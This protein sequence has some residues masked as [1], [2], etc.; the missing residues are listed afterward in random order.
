MGPRLRKVLSDVLLVFNGAR[1]VAIVLLTVAGISILAS[2]LD[3]NVSTSEG[4]FVVSGT[5]TNDVRTVS[6][7]VKDSQDEVPT[8][9]LEQWDTVRMRVTAYCP[10]RI[11]CGRY[12]DGFTA[13]NHKIK[14]GDVFVAADKKYRFG[15]EVIVPGY[16][17]D[18]PVKVLDRG[19]VI[20]GDRL[21]VFFNSHRTAKKWGVKHLDVKVKNQE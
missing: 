20:K 13:C 7:P 10:C 18:K 8:V 2:I 21:D 11:C 6:T 9:D 4:E 16:N 1:L 5:T 14:E 17:Q 15:T 12:A 3:A 19:R